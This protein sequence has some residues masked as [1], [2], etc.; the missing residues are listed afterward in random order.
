M[1]VQ[2][3]SDFKQKSTSA[4]IAIILFIIVY[5]LLFLSA[6]AL[7]IGC[8][9]A[10]LWIISIKPMFFTVMIGIG[11]ASLGILISYFLIKFLFKKH[12]TDRSDLTE[13]TRNDEPQ[14]FEM[15][16]G[17]VKEAGTDFPKKVYLAYDVNASVF[18]DSS[19][20]SMFLPIKKNLI[21]GIGLVN[22]CTKQELK[23]IL[24]HEFGHFSQRS[25][26]VGSYVY[27]VNQIIFN[28]VN[29]D[30]AY[31][32]TVQGWANASGYF[33]FFAELAVKITQGIQW[34]LRKMY[35]FVNIRHMAL[36]REMEFHADEVAA[37]I[38]GSIALEESLLRLDLAGNSY[39]SVIDFY[40]SKIEESKTSKNIYKEQNFVMNYFAKESELE[41][42]YNLPVVK[43]SEAGLFN[44]SKLVIEN[45]WASHPSTE[46]R[47]A[48]L[49]QLNIIKDPDNSSARTLFKNIDATEEELTTKI[50]SNVQYEKPK[51]ELDL[52]TFQDEFE[53]NYNK[54]T[55]DKIFN[56]YYDN[57]NP[58]QFDLSSAVPSPE[59]S[60]FDELFSKDKVESVYTLIALEN[61]RNTISSIADKTFDVKTFD[62]DGRKFKAKEAKNLIPK[63][64][65]Q[66]KSLQE[67]ITQNDINIY[68][69]FLN[70]AKS[71]NMEFELRQSF[72]DFYDHDKNYEEKFG[73][74]AELSKALGFVSVT[75]P[76][77]RIIKNFAKLKPLETKLKQ[78]LQEIIDNP[79]LKEEINEQNRKDLEH[80][81]NNDL[82][83]FN[84]NEYL[85]TNLQQLFFA[86][87]SY[88][89]YIGRKFFL[90][91]KELL[92]KMSSLEKTLIT[93]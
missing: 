59:A 28:L 18:Y 32:N 68:H 36:S 56:N 50:F 71:K 69:Y 91:K 85:N 21:I 43:I 87:N 6:I 55:F 77:E 72:S 30:E 41:L 90:L 12:I 60:N 62:Y 84:Q 76:F 38:A 29:E 14:L 78:E 65:E 22:A 92:S 25:M 35:S 86:V 66:I 37:N 16:H 24:A 51:S 80:Y 61:D 75:T 3:S 5:I 93:E 4:I 11:L 49:R 88:H 27:N 20:W 33:A 70:L 74:F 42:K 31:R 47:V 45:Q 44:K 1:F 10:G 8:I 54:D 48:K 34:I 23:A 19:F 52:D 58:N 46:D 53:K 17:I 64:D 67:E 89:F 73:L 26:K 39:S 15:I 2:V 40:N 57:K 83:Y 13:I 82:P 9:A 81:I 63:L 7:T 79:L